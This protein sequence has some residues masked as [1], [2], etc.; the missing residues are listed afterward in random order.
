MITYLEVLHK[1]KPFKT[2]GK[3]NLEI[4]ANIAAVKIFNN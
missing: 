3:N 4:L 2:K 1:L